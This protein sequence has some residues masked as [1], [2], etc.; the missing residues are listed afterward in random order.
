M[1]LLYQKLKQCQYFYKYFAANKP[2]AHFLNNA[3]QLLLN[4]A[5][6]DERELQIIDEIGRSVW[7]TRYSNDD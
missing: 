1:W 5:N 4:T 6:L 2:Y 3:R 7:L